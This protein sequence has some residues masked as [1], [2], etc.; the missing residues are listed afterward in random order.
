LY[1]SYPAFLKRFTKPLRKKRNSIGL[2]I[3]AW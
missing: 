2:Q 3:S 1:K